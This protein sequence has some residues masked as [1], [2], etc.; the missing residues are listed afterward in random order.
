MQSKQVGMHVVQDTDELKLSPEEQTTALEWFEIGYALAI[1]GEMRQA[2]DALET[3]VQKEPDYP[4]AWLLLSSVLLAGGM[5]T[6]AEKAGKMVLNLCPGLG[7]TWP[8]LR[9]IIRTNAFKGGSS[10]RTGRRVTFDNPSG[11]WASIIAKVKEVSQQSLREIPS[12]EPSLS[13]TPA[14]SPKPAGSTDIE[15]REPPHDEESHDRIKRQESRLTRHEASDGVDEPFWT[16]A[17]DLP[18]QLFSQARTHIKRGEYKMA[19]RALIKFL[20]MD[21]E[22]GEAWL[23]LGILLLKRDSLQEARDALENALRKSPKEPHAYLQMAILLQRMKKWSEARD[24]AERARKLDPK[25]SE[26]SFRLGVCDFE[27]RSYKEAAQNFLRVLRENPNHVEALFYLARTMQR[28]G[29]VRHA[30]NIYHKLLSMDIDSVEMLTQ[31]SQ[32]LFR[33]GKKREAAQ[34]RRRLAR[35]RAAQRSDG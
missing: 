33:L 21:P 14:E 29:N 2:Q 19:E 15:E 24:Y 18:E 8:R 7:M 30:F 16:E 12:P 3:A 26:T 31:L 27:L 25:N 5:E 9:G 6:N 32:E 1:K 4:L 13:D 11:Q 23:H 35:L 22:N 10:L 17:R 28:R 34:V 20:S